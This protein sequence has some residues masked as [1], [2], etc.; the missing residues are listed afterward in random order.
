MDANKNMNIFR[1]IHFDNLEDTLRNGMY[2]RNSGHIVPNFVNIGDTTL[3][4]QRESF[5]VPVNPP[6]GNLGDYIPFYFAGHSP[7]LL[8]IKTGARGIQKQ[9][10]KDLI[11]I[12]CKVHE[13]VKHCPQWCFTDGHAKNHLTKFFN[14]LGQ[15]DNLDWET[16]RSQYWKDTEEDYDRMRRKQAEFLVKT[17]VPATCIRG[18]IVL[19]RDQENKA[20]EIM[21]NAGLELP[22]YID[23]KRKYFY[24]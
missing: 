16:I 15:L 14:N 23:T 18:L 8:N 13:I 2:S 4:K 10:Q 17:H 21:Q 11:Y 1:L 20:K 24:P 3:I 5:T 7:M 6:N 9:D 19:N 22:I 12:V